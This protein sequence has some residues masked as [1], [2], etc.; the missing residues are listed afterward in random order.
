MEW[1]EASDSEEEWALACEHSDFAISSQET[2]EAERRCG[3]SFFKANLQVDGC[4][5][6]FRVVF[7]VLLWLRL[8]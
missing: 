6:C 2:G 7:W 8:G 5:T 4:M 3:V 1:S